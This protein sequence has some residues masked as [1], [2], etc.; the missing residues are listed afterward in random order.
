MTASVSAVLLLGLLQSDRRWETLT[1]KSQSLGE[2]CEMDPRHAIHQRFNWR[3][4]SHPTSWLSKL[5][6]S[7]SS[8]IYG[9]CVCRCC[10]AETCASAEPKLA[11]VGGI[12]FSASHGG[13]SDLFL[14]APRRVW[15]L[16]LMS[17]STKLPSAA[18][19]AKGFFPPNI[20][21]LIWAT[22]G[23][24]TRAPANNSIQPKKHEGLASFMVAGA[25]RGECAQA[26]R[27]TVFFLRNPPSPFAG[28]M[29][30]QRNENSMLRTTKWQELELLWLEQLIFTIFQQQHVIV[31]YWQSLISFYA[32]ANLTEEKK[33]HNSPR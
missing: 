22:T 21:R 16:F 29:T 9:G 20:P 31:V 19:E 23:N 7:W 26:A 24:H 32:I 12:E 5:P 25:W 15:V 6:L 18:S 28:W 27:R 8:L 30:F 33:N 14:L 11:W 2:S 1:A 4:K 17:V 3:N 10:C 13:A